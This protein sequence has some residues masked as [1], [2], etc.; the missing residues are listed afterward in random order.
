MRLRPLAVAVL[1]F[2]SA[3][4]VL[5]QRPMR[6]EDLFRVGSVGKIA[7]A[8]DRSRAAVE[9]TDARRWLD[10]GIPQGRISVVDVRSGRLRTVSPSSPAYVGF[11][12]PAWSPD[13]RRLLFLSVD[14]GAVVRPWLWTAGADRPVMLRGLVLRDAPADPPVALWKDASHAL[15]LLR[16]PAAP[17]SG[18]LYVA[19]LR[20]RNTARAWEKAHAGREAAVAVF[21]SQGADSADAGEG[22]SHLVS[23]DVRTGASETLARGALHRPSVSPDGSTLTYHVE[24]PLFAAAPVASFFGP[25]ARGDAAYDAPNWGSEVRHL[26]LRTGREAAAPSAA[27]PAGPPPGP[28]APS[29]RVVTTPAEGTRLL[30][31]RPGRPDVELWRGNAWLKEIE[32]GP[33]MPIAYSSTGGDP[34]AG[35]LL[36]PPGYTP[37][38]RIPIVAY[39]YPGTLDTARAPWNFDVLA[40]DF[41]NPQLLAALGYGVV[42]PSMPLADRLLESDALKDLPNGVL[43]LLDTLVARG[44]ADSSRIAVLGQS[45]GGWATMGL[46]TQTDRFRTA[47]ASAGYPDLV[48][49][50]GSFYGQFRYGDAGSG[51]RAQV[52]R[53]LQFE[54]GM[55]GAGA[56]PWDD[57]AAYRRNSPIWGVAR[58]HTPLLLVQGDE[59]FIPVQQAEE[60][61]TALYRQDKRV[62]LLR[63]TGE[64]HTLSARADVLDFWRR[65]AEWLRATMPPAD[66]SGN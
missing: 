20:G 33:A 13:G 1:A 46:I 7:W 2:A 36:L 6:P 24:D 38:R 31:E 62:R 37:G 10:G 49:L 59:D 53:M 11:F 28:D 5:A 32:P 40:S 21:D 64:G 63:Y 52:L 61:F 65:L 34:L 39:V 45:A 27:A 47:V 22:D 19:I 42:R 55:F 30:L 58:V 26:D 44:I 57:P 60:F 25:G 23:V 4:R 66:S 29:L 50:Y 17:L 12:A 9:I 15:F 54:R 3:P 18:P 56:A 41:E 16:D 48:S 35:W 14:T 8:P 51:R 43:P